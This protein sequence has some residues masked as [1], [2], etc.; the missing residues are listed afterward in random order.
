MA[1]GDRRGAYRIHLW[2]AI[3]RY[4][5]S[6][7]IAMFMYITNMYWLWLMVALPVRA[8][9][10]TAAEYIHCLRTWE[11]VSFYPRYQLRQVCCHQ[12]FRKWSNSDYQ[13]RKEVV[14][15]AE[16]YISLVLSLDFIC[17]HTAMNLPRLVR[18]AQTSIAGA[19][20]Y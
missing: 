19:R 20:E 13:S 3:H 18:S 15:V 16:G 2:A 11:Y 12:M 10:C 8:L 6:A 9:V 7:Y 1:V 17:G 5:Y 4:T 14:E